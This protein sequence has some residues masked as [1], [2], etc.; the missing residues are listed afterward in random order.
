MAISTQQY[1]RAMY[2]FL[3]GGKADEL[4]QRV[5]SIA[6]LFK[7]DRLFKKKAMILAAYEVYAKKQEGAVDIEI[8]AAYPPEENAV[9]QIKK[10]LGTT[11]NAVIKGDRSLIGGFRIRKE[12]TIIDASVKTQIERLRNKLIHS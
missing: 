9:T 5:L 12:Y 11:G 8:T 10:I 2:E 4:D 6:T 3:H 7:R 1:A